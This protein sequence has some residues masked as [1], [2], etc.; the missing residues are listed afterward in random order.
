METRI[1][2]GAGGGN[3]GEFGTWKNDG[4]VNRVTIGPSG[5]SVVTLT[6]LG[7]STPPSDTVVWPPWRMIINPP[8][9]LAG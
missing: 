8:S 7:N 1:V 5:V 9:L 2:A 6:F 4:I 3:G